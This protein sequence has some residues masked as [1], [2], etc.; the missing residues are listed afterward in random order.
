MR[1]ARP[2]PAP[3]ADAEDGS[4]QQA[5]ATCVHVSAQLPAHRHSL[6]ALQAPYRPAMLPRRTRIMVPLTAAP[7]AADVTTGRACICTKEQAASRRRSAGAGS[8]RRSRQPA[9]MPTPALDGLFKCSVRLCP[10]RS[11]PSASS[12]A[13]SRG[14]ARCHRSPQTAAQAGHAPGSRHG[15]EV[16]MQQVERGIKLN[17]SRMRGLGQ[18]RAS[19]GLHTHACSAPSRPFTSQ[20]CQHADCTPEAPWARSSN[21]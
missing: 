19:T 14:R 11:H 5:D 6:Q 4:D 7:A 18:S 16:D 12:E 20:A 17:E 8:G 2:P 13:H 15:A 1:K 10:R 9:P 21:W 3:V